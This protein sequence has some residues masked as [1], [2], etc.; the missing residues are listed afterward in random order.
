MSVY[1][2]P[3]AQIEEQI[4]RG[5]LEA[6]EGAPASEEKDEPPPRS[7]LK[8]EVRTSTVYMY[9]ICTWYI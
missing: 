6:L 2:R 7:Q 8:K 9:M 5:L 3:C 1:P 4:Q